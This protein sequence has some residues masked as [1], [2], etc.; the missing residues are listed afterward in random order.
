LFFRSAKKI[1]TKE[2]PTKENPTE[3]DPAKEDPDFESPINRLINIRCLSDQRFQT[4]A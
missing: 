4:K 2:D 1:P 3:E